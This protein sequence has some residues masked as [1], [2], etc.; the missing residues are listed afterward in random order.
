MDKALYSI[1]AAKV[2]R[3]RREII[4]TFWSKLTK[5]EREVMRLR[6]YSELTY[7]EIMRRLSLSRDSVR[8]AE[9]NALNK[10]RQYPLKGEK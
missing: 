2:D 5:V 4:M 10:F 3:H 9:Q 7:S 8:R 6:Y 1:L